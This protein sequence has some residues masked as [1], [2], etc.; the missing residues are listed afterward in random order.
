MKRSLLLLVLLILAVSGILLWRSREQ[1]PA[2]RDEAALPSAPAPAAPEATP[3]A[4]EISAPVSVELAR[5]VPLER[6]AIDPT[7]PGIVRGAAMPVAAA[8]LRVIG[9]VQDESG[10]PVEGV[11]VR[12]GEGPFE[13]Q[14]AFE[15][16]TGEEERDRKGRATTDSDGRFT[17]ELRRP[18]DV[19]LR[20]RAARHAPL[21]VARSIPAGELYDAG[22]FTLSAGPVVTGRVVD[23]RGAGVGGAR[24]SRTLG[25]DPNDGILWVVDGSSGEALGE[26][27][28]DGSFELDILPAGELELAVESD[29]HPT[30][31]SKLEGSLRADERRDGVVLRLE[32]GGQISGVALGV[33]EG[34]IDVLRVHAIERRGER[35]GES[36]GAA[37]AS[38]SARLEKDG[39]FTVRGVRPDAAYDVS[40]RLNELRLNELRLN[41]LRL[42]EGKGMLSLA[43]RM[44]REVEARAGDRGLQLEYQPDSALVF[45][46]VDARTKAP[47]ESFRVEGSLD[48]EHARW[49]YFET[50]DESK[51]HPGGRGKLGNLRRR[52]D[53]DT[54]NLWITA[55]GYR[56]W[57]R[58]DIPLGP[59]AETDLGTIELEPAPLLMV[60]VLDAGSGAPVAGAR[61]SLRRVREERGVD[62]V[63][64]AR[65]VSFGA[66][67]DGPEP[68]EFGDQSSATAR[69]DESGVARLNSFEGARCTL[70][71]EHA[72]HAPHRSEPFTCAVG[73][74]EA[75]E[76]RLSV[77]GSVRVTLKDV[78]GRP[79]AGAKIERRMARVPGAPPAPLSGPDRPEVTDA[80]G[81]VVFRHL[82]PGL[83]RFRPDSSSMSFGGGD[84]QFV[85]AGIMGGEQEPGWVEA[86]VA[87]NAETAL[88][89]LAPLRVALRGVVTEG[90]AP[91]AG[92]LVT[93][94]RKADAGE[95]SGR[96]MIFGM[97]GGPSG[98]TDGRGRYEVQNVKSGDYTAR[99]THKSRAM[100]AEVDVTIGS[101]DRE[102]DIAL[103]V[104]VIEGRVTGP[105]GKPVARAKVTVERPSRIRRTGAVS[106]VVAFAGGER[107]EST[108]MLGGDEPSARTDE[109]GRYSLR[110][111]KPGVKLVV[112]AKAKDFRSA[113][114]EELELGPNEARSRVDLQLLPSGS[115]EVSVFRGG[116]PQAEGIVFAWLVGRKP[117]S[118]PSQAVLQEGRAR[119]EDLEGGR[120]IVTVRTFGRMISEREDGESKQEVVVE[121]G[122]TAS[123]RF[124][125]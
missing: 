97:G 5:E 53:S 15:Q 124:D 32:P 115:I 26:T 122:K 57:S 52:G 103:D 23:S 59:G 98:R 121:A 35:E 16:A 33:P 70:A 4:G 6:R 107:D 49:P 3:A 91:L 117:G 1:A 113:K 55:T 38:R 7:Q 39:T 123:L 42:N 94:E 111:V 118:D 89:L 65:T 110:G 74:P 13:F 20:L 44:S 51:A 27:R 77:G 34:T 47:L 37:R 2:Q 62:G 9:R 75:R 61:V 14:I 69:T 8:G 120:W 81:V 30:L 109:D 87:E 86:A 93:L 11:K 100:P 80:S 54:A 41:E 106:M 83:H 56:E 45:T 114:S 125:L 71:V 99:V 104:A 85:I 21:D 82:A 102:L 63:F 112:K 58:L 31:R 95:E 105:D 79:V 66:S 12:A 25:G 48:K 19:T 18:G 17:L 76:V 96:M 72:E 28:A 40:L 116:E 119:L 92:A 10:A 43:P 24:I 68:L 64:I 46:V 84:V 90:G 36:M 88:E 29:E 50:G 60:T 108:M 67:S 101:D 73:Q 22:T 78:Q